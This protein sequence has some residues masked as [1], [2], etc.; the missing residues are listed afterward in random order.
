MS[1]GESSQTSP[2]K[3]HVQS[4]E[5]AFAVLEAFD[6]EHP[7][8]TLSEAAELT[9]LDRAAARRYLLTLETLGYVG[10]SGRQFFLRPRVLKL[11]YSYLSSLSL[12]QLAQPFLQALVEATGESASLTV[13]DGSEIAYIAVANSGRAFTI[14]LTVGNRLP[15]YCTAM[16]RVLLSGLDR[17]RLEAAL[18]DSPPAP[19][20]S[21]TVYQPDELITLIEEVRRR[22]WCIVDQELENGV[23]SIA[24]PI[25]DASGA[26]SAALSVTAPAARVR[27]ATLRTEIREKLERTASELQDHISGG[28]A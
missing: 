24:V 28:S 26:I 5:R 16:G 12:P 3:T 11:G 15:A 17:S 13:L 6:T 2:N 18:Q 27:V 23:R 21:T 4:L 19:H 9:G 10:S 25:V 1:G 14:K 8:L 20:T 22:G 7:T